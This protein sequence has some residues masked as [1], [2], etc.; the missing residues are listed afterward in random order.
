MNNIVV[1]G[2]T[3][4]IGVSLIKAAIVD[5]EIKQIYAVVRPGTNKFSRLPTDGKIIVIECGVD[6]YNNLPQLVQDK[7]DIFF[8]LAWPRTPTYDESFEDTYEKAQNILYVMDALKAAQELGCKSFVGTGSQSEYGIV[9]SGKISTKTACRPVRTDGVIHLAAGRLIEM[10]AGEM[11]LNSAWLR[12]FSIYGTNDRDNSLIKST[13]QK[14][15]NGERCAFTK[16]EQ[17]WDYL[18]EDDAGRAFLE[19]GKRVQGNRTYNLGYGAA[20]PL[21]EYISII[22]D[23][24]APEASLYFGELPYPRDPV[25]NLQCDVSS[26]SEDTG[27]HPIVTFEEGIHRILMS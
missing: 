20:R 19:V 13:I 21:K 25:M 15:K 7:I 14:L 18:Y 11:G 26:L 3:S 10:T 9:E 27:W 17:M 5:D 16:S 1:T 12:V 23:I 8:H 4:M 2:A 24:I 22:R 6:T